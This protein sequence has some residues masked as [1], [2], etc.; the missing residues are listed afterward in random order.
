MDYTRWVDRATAFLKQL[1][2]RRGARVKA[3]ARSS[4]PLPAAAVS[5]IEKKIDR[6]VPKPIQALWMDTTSGFDFRYEWNLSTEL[7]ERIGGLLS[8]QGRLFGGARLCPARDLATLLTDCSD[9]A[10][11]TWISDS[12]Y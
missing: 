10:N 12:A 9:W 8:G 2:G 11:S 3:R 5:A 6:P 7:R 1:C 4:P